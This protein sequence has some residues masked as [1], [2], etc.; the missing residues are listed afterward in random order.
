MYNAYNHINIV[1][2]GEAKHEGGTVAVGNRMTQI[3]S[4]TNTLFI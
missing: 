1:A 4:R 3:G 2:D